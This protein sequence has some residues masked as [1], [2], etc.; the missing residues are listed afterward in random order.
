VG[1]KK[2]E[3][4]TGLQEKGKD[5]SGHDDKKKKLYTG[6]KPKKKTR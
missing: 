4:K 1:G 6:E 5:V 3:K 2:E